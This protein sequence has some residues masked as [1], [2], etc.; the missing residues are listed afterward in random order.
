MDIIS[1]RMKSKNSQ[2]PTDDVKRLAFLDLLIAART[3]NGENLKAADIQEEVDTF[4]F[5][6]HDTNAAA[7]TWGIYL[8]GRHPEV[9]DQIIKEIDA[10]FGD[11]KR[12]PA[13]MDDLRKLT[14]L[15][16]VS[17]SG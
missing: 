14:F 3:E 1:S 4:M 10:V 16:G 8:I 7:L 12:R 15:I 11:D 2:S 6:G 17:K 13:T 5:A 9:Q